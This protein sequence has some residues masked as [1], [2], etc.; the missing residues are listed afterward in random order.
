MTGGIALNRPTLEQGQKRG[1]RESVPRSSLFL[2]QDQ[3]VDHLMAH[4]RTRRKKR[5]AFLPFWGDL[6]AGGRMA[7]VG[8]ADTLLAWFP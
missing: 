4:S 7:P 1:A 8:D 5:L 6:S 3:H 2:S